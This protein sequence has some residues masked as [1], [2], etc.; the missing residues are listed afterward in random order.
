M[1]TKY[2]SSLAN[3]ALPMPLTANPPVPTSTTPIALS[4]FF[5]A[6]RSG[7]ETRPKLPGSEKS[8]PFLV[9]YRP[10]RFLNADQRSYL[11]AL[12]VGFSTLQLAYPEHNVDKSTEKSSLL[13][14]LSMRTAQETGYSPSRANKIISM[15]FDTIATVLAEYLSFVASVQLYTGNSRPF[16]LQD[17]LVSFT[18]K[19]DVTLQQD[20]A[21]LYFNYPMTKEQTNVISMRYR[22]LPRD[23]QYMTTDKQMMQWGKYRALLRE[24][25]NHLTE[26]WNTTLKLNISLS[27]DDSVGILETRILALYAKVQT[28]RGTMEPT[29]HWMRRFRPYSDIMMK[30]LLRVLEMFAIHSSSS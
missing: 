7:L 24:L 23:A 26:K 27:S 3:I 4:S 15:E 20:L 17:N 29:G 2:P 8:F 16:S 13:T 22:P 5:T 18:S 21:T 28:E 19:P 12:I 9:D 1:S 11:D 10:I 6:A 14:P 25:H 30:E